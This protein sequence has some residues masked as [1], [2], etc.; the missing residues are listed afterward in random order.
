[1]RT[2]TILGAAATLATA[3]TLPAIAQET[4]RDPGLCARFPGHP[5]CQNYGPGNPYTDG[6]RYRRHHA[7]YRTIRPARREAW[8]NGYDPYRDRPAYGPGDVAAGAVGTAGA[9]AAGAINT[10][11][12]IATAPFRAADSY[13][14]YGYNGGYNGGW[15]GQNY[16]QRNGFVCTP[17]TYFRGEDGRRYLCQ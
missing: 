7:V 17:G 12:A 1:M 13:A 14:Y 5:T 15:S 6:S 16:A 4:M 11:G 3:L 10:A 2:L 9:V 8:N